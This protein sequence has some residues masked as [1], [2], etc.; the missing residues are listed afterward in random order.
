[1]YSFAYYVSLTTQVKLSG[2]FVPHVVHGAVFSR[3]LRPPRARG[4]ITNLPARGS[5]RLR[6]WLRRGGES[7]A[8]QFLNSSVI[9]ETLAVKGLSYI[10]DVRQGH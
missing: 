5:L 4:G 8:S 1:M 9:V 10:E 6:L 7:L 3:P 2:D